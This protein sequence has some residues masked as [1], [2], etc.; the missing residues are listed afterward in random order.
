MNFLLLV[1]VTQFF[2][3]VVLMSFLIFESQPIIAFKQIQNNT[4]IMFYTFVIGHK[5]IAFKISL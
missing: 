3:N 2:S 5:L 4:G 1:L